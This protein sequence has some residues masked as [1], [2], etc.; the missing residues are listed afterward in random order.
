MKI[1]WS[2]AF[3][4]DGELTFTARDCA[5]CSRLNPG[6]DCICN[7]IQFGSA[8]YFARLDRLHGR[9]QVT[10]PAAG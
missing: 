4:R 1:L 5:I 8:E 10:D 6:E 2:P 3:A 9:G 7:S